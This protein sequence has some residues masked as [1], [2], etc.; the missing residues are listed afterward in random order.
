MTLKHTENSAVISIE[1]KQTADGITE[2]AELISEGRFYKTGDKFYIFYNE[3][4]TEKTSA[5]IVQITVEEKRLIMSR[6]G[7]FS[8]KMEYE[9]GVANDFTY[10]TPFG[11]MLMQLKTEAFENN[12][13]EAGGNLKLCY[14]LIINGEE[15][16]NDL[17]IT[18]RN[19]R[20][21]EK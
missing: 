18:V 2:T 7:E 15:M 4:E 6:K 17:T 16:H 19:E 10:H 14:I 1:N 11:D 12:L 3:E 21:G 5:C 20:G 13:T 9:A 8:S